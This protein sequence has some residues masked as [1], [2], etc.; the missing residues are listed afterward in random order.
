[1]M[2]VVGENVVAGFFCITTAVYEQTA[3]TCDAILFSG[4]DVAL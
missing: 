1:M 2:L 4:D 3:V